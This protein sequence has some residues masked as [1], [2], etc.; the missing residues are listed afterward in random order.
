ML[1]NID[2]CL[3][4]RDIWCTFA[5][6]NQGG[7]MNELT[8]I[9]YARL[10]QTAAFNYCGVTLGKTQINKILFYIYGV[11]LALTGNRLFEDDSPQAW[12]HGPVFP[13]VYRRAVV[14]EV[15]KFTEAEREAF[16]N[17]DTAFGIVCNVCRVMPFYSAVDL[18]Y[19]SH[20]DGS[21]WSETI[22]Q[23]DR[24][25]K[26]TQNPWGTVIKD[27]VI[28]KYFENERNRKFEG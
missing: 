18:T 1:Y 9:D 16:M 2:I 7:L 26:L 21:P 27:D 10:I 28:C 5:G 20:E 19:W 14:G 12:V 25:G 3:V 13:R 15:P 6:E 4:G 17:N 11:Y 8:S 22:Y 23:H 24:Y